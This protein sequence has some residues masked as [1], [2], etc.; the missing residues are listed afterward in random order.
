MTAAL[1]NDAKPAICNAIFHCGVNPTVTPHTRTSM[2]N[3]VLI[4]T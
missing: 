2:R 4:A 1:P 3:T